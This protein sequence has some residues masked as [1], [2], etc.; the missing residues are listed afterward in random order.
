MRRTC[1][2]IAL[3]VLALSIPVV[4]SAGEVVTLRASGHGPTLLFIPG[5]GAPAGVWDDVVKELAPRFTCVV[6]SIAGFASPAS[7]HALEI[8]VLESAI[9]RE[10]ER[11]H[12]RKPVLVG[13]S[14]GGLLALSLAASYPDV[15]GKVVIVDAYPFPMG[16]LQPTMSAEAARQQAAAVRA[17]LMKLTDVEFAA[18]QRAVAAMSVSDPARAEEVV[19]WTL[20]SDRATIAD[21]QFAMLASDLR[22]R[23]SRLA[24][25]LMVIGTW[26][27]R[28]AF[29]FTHE[30][31]AQQLDAQYAAVAEHRIVVNDTAR[32]Y[33]MLDE[34]SWLASTI[35]EFVGR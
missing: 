14:F 17:A 22:P 5:I 31:T 9:A 25:P 10:V 26:R 19:G 18:Q 24:A 12:W 29:G 7:T 11:G 6:V 30:R 34:P 15:F 35:A 2:A 32:H 28:E 1:R 21:A 33:V 16:Q 23:L 3:S 27:G 4:A 13:H 20:A 8:G